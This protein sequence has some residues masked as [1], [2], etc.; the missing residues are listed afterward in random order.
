MAETT[1]AHKEVE[2]VRDGQAHREFMRA[3]LNDVRAL[4]RML[5]EGTFESGQRR[6]GAEQEMF[7]IDRAWS[8]A[9]G[10]VAMLERLEDPH[11]TT[12]L[13]QFQLEANCDP[14]RLHGDGIAQ[15]HAQLDALVAKARD[16]ANGLGMD[17]V[18]MGILPTL[19]KADLGLDAMVPSPRYIAM[20]KMVTELRGGRFELSIKGLDE[21]II[22][23]DSVMLE[24]CNS[25]FQVHLQVDPGDFARRYNIAQ[26]LLGPLMSV[27]ANSPWCSAAGSGPRPASRCFA[28]PSTPAATRT[29]S[30]RPRPG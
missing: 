18:L 29:T 12:E 3:L 26:V 21:L 22:D 19:R 23:H 5:A 17:V 27:S 10:A 4:E 13:G 16:A 20:N 15:M 24:A 1:R 14:Q 30:A 11:Y 25:S 9:R 2:T 7:L 6:I 28:R 8:P